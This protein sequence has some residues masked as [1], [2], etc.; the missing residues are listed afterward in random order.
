MSDACRKIGA[1]AGGS[2]GFTLLEIM[3]AIFIFALV[4][5]TVFGSFRVVFSSAEA[6]G[7]DVALFET[8]RT[9]LGR[10]ATDLAALH[11]SH[12]PMYRKPEFNDPPDPYRLVGDRTDVAGGTFG[13]LRFASQAHLPINGDTRQG[14][15]RIVYYVHQRADDSLVLR[16][17]DDLYPFP[18]FEESD[19]DPVLCDRVL[20]LDFGYVQADGTI[21]EAWD[22]ESED[23]EYTTP[24]LIEIHLTVGSANRPTTFTTRVPLYAYRQAA[25]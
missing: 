14:V 2:R 10:M 23:T 5:T 21:E 19:D 11:V 6:V 4:I 20:S 13:R 18:E 16:R 15:C 25:D 7:G 24:R 17:A 1:T 12:Y 22:S 9:C 8:A 3:V